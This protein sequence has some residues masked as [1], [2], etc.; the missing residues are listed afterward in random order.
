MVSQTSAPGH[1]PSYAPAPVDPV[2]LAEALRPFGES[3]MLP[4]A[5]YTDPA[6]FDWERRNFLGGGWVCLARGAQL[7][8]PGAQLAVG[9]GSGGVLL[10]RGEDGVVRAFANTCR[11]RGHE[12]LPCG[13]SA[14][15][16][17]IVCPYHNWAYELS[18][19]LRGAPGFRDAPGFSPAAWP[20]RQVPAVE[21]HG[22]VLADCSGG[23]AG[24]LPLAALEEIVHVGV[25]ARGARA[26]R[27]RPGLR[28]RLLG[29]D[30]PAGLGRLRV[31]AARAGLPS[32]LPRAAGT[33]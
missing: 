18:G 32:R 3:R 29:P 15:G 19:E 23:T 11:H 1:R 7:P 12:L 17:A 26:A 9:T 6:V 21:W 10:A 24:P 27:L 2:E 14:I 28:G 22:L 31:G 25:R 33:G 30:Q 8:A 20:L 16:K 4:R 5:A 13:S